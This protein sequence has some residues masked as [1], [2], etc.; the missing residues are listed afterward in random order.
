M[1]AA[2]L[3]APVTRLSR[4]LP[5]PWQ[6]FFFFAYCTSTLRWEISLIVEIRDEE[7]VRD[8]RAGYLAVV[9]LE[10]VQFR[11]SVSSS[12]SS[13][14]VRSR[15]LDRIFISMRGVRGRRDTWNRHRDSVGSLV[16]ARIDYDDTVL[17]DELVSPTRPAARRIWSLLFFFSMFTYNL[18]ACIVSSQNPH[19]SCLSRLLTLNIT[20]TLYYRSQ[21]GN[22]PLVPRTFEVPLYDAR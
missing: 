8:M 9:P 19:V 17:D 20:F 4:R 21:P 1:A 5:P 3:D 10:E 16:W 18:T 15:D 7:Q 14:R 2:V 11:R 13:P 12:V 22:E 6:C